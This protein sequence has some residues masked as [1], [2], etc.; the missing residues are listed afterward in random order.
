MG[1]KDVTNVGDINLTTTAASHARVETTAIG[2]AHAASVSATGDTTRGT[3][4]GLGLAILPNINKLTRSGRL[5]YC[6]PHL[7]D[8]NQSAHE[9]LVAECRHGLLRLFPSGIL[10]NSDALESA[11]CRRRLSRGEI[12]L[13]ASLKS[14]R[15]SSQPVN[16]T[17]IKDQKE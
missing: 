7:S 14:P 11:N 15:T 9:I 6:G 3:K 12:D 13:P 8:V 1:G 16:P 5:C 4:S 10:H 17:S 2:A